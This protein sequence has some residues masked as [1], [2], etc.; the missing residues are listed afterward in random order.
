MPDLPEVSVD[1]VGPKRHSSR[2]A[3][4]VASIALAA[5]FVACATLGAPA[6]QGGLGP[7]ETVRIET[8]RGEIVI[9]VFPQAMPKTVA[10]FKKLVQSGFYNGLTWHRVEDWVVQ[11]GDPTA[12]GAGGSGVNV[13]FETTPLLPNTRGAVGMA[14][15]ANDMN[16]ATSQ[17]YILKADA[18]GLNG[19]YAVF[20]RV[21][22]GMNVVA[23]LAKGDKI[24]RATL[25][26]L[27]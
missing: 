21:V 12:T 8:A 14:R 3:P 26:Q 18:Q 20:G 5:L 11:T 10:N 4:M 19:Q 6:Q 22:R 24:V 27:K 25:E 1:M 7:S 17:F 2:M 16:S 15:R 13:A 23:A 9:E